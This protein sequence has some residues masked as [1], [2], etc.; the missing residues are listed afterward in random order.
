MQ[1]NEYKRA[2]PGTAIQKL[3]EM[4]MT[5]G[6][7]EEGVIGEVSYSFFD[8]EGNTKPE[9]KFAISL[10]ADHLKNMV[11]EGKDV[12]MIAGRYKEK[13]LAAA[14]KGK[15]GNVLITDDRTAKQLLESDSHS[16]L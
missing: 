8:R 11:R 4:D 5:K 10:D 13:A 16:E 9:W 7:A 3:A 15:I 6:L 14:L 12:V 2:S 1:S